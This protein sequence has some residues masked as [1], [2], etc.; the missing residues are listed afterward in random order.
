[1]LIFPSVFCVNVF[2]IERAA[3]APQLSRPVQAGGCSVGEAA[4][5]FPGAYGRDAGESGADPSDSGGW[6]KKTYSYRCPRP[7]ERYK[8]V[9]ITLITVDTSI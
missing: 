7:R 5:L 8:L 2:P 6:G 4:D 9:N 3:G 1:M